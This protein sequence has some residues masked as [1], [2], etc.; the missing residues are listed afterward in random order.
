MVALRTT[1]LDEKVFG[2]SFCRGL[3]IT[4]FFGSSVGQLALDKNLGGRVGRAKKQANTSRMSSARLHLVSRVTAF[5]RGG[6]S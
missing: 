5:D 6:T 3:L 2:E 1:H 4:E